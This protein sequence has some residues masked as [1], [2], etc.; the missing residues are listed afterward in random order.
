MNYPSPRCILSGSQFEITVGVGTLPSTS[1]WKQHSVLTFF[2]LGEASHMNVHS[3]S[4]HLPYTPACASTF[5]KCTL[6]SKK[7]DDFLVSCQ[8]R[9]LSAQ[10]EC[11][12]TP[13]PITVDVEHFATFARILPCNNLSKSPLLSIFNLSR[14]SAARALNQSLSPQRSP[15]RN[16]VLL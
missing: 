8:S 11:K 12:F 2:A 1:D 13:S 9:Q 14:L 4:S 3:H 10:S 5:L 6:T 16:P 7:R 15:C